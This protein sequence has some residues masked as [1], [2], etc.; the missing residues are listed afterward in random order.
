MEMEFVAV[1]EEVLVA[2]IEIKG[3]RRSVSVEMLQ[4]TRFR[5]QPDPMEMND[6]H[7]RSV[8]GVVIVTD[9]SE[10]VP[11]AVEVIRFPVVKLW[12]SRILSVENVREESANEK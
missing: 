2:L 6:W 12:I 10:S 9:A 7:V 5:E 8:A 3:A 11:F 1:V 4:S